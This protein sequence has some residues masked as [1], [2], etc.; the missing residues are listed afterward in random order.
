MVSMKLGIIGTGAIGARVAQKAVDAGYSVVLSNSRGPESLRE[1]A[2]ALGERASAAPVREAAEQEIV[3]LAVPWTKVNEAVKDLPDWG[4]RIVIDATNPFI[5]VSPVVIADVEPLTSSETVAMALPGARVVKA[6]N[7]MYARY[8]DGETEGG[9]RVL[10]YAGDDGDAKA[11][12]SDMFRK[13]GFYPH[14]LG[15]LA[16]GGRIMQLG[17]PL[18]AAH[19][20]HRDGE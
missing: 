3:L 15:N 17:G 2:Q 6:F 18:A 11:Q 13:M 7:A 19:F 12:A 14:D 5:S 4:G 20:I 10:F 8:I 9:R 16:M 1:L